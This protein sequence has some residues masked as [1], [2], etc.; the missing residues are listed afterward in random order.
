MNHSDVRQGFEVLFAITQTHQKSFQRKSEGVGAWSKTPGIS[1]QE[2]SD[3]AVLG[4]F[5]LDSESRGK[6]EVLHV[7]LRCRKRLGI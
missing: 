1:S 3:R 4:P 7:C 5:T 6:V 2:T